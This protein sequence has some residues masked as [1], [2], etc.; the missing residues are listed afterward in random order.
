MAS[1][2]I[3]VIGGSYFL[4]DRK[5]AVQRSVN[6]Y[7]MRVEGFGED[8]QM[9]LESAPG[10][11]LVATLAGDVR[12]MR[13]AD[14]RLFVVAGTTLYE[15]VGGIAINRGAVPAGDRVS[16]TNG[17]GQLA[18][19]TSSDLLVFSLNTNTLSTVA[20]EGWRG[21]THVEYLDGYFVF[22]A[23]GTDQFYISAIDDADELDALEFSSADTQ[24]DN[25]IAHVVRKREAYFFGTR[26]CEVW[27]NSGDPDFPFAR[28][29]GTP[30]D[31]GAVGPWSVA[32]A[33]DTLVWVGQTERGGPYVYRMDGYQPVRISDQ[34]VE[35]L[36]EAADYANATCWAYQEAGGE[37]V[38]I[39][40]P[41]MSTTLVWDASTGIW[42]ERAELVDG[43]WQRLRVDHH[44][45]FNGAHYVGGGT[46]L[47]RM[48]R[49]Y[50]SL[51]GDARVMER[52]FPHFL[53]P[54]LEPIS[55]PGLE[56]RCTTGSDTQGYITLEVSN[57]GG[58]VF[59]PPLRRSLGAQGQRQ[60]RVRWLGLGTCPAGGS[61]VFRLRCTDAVHLTIQG[62]VL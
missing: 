11:E 59:G 24:P 29:Q 54:S 34:C 49:E 4:R 55:Y 42:H 15:F 53:Q 9:V 50:A 43:A 18:I 7:P 48:S 12:G 2:D 30:I 26:S 6:C 45:Y 23:P 41:G 16:M 22:V 31:V 1:R 35:Q 28:Y 32:K 57:D 44:A 8:T 37:F 56:I 21:S 60:Q 52:T 13:N 20:S 58:S 39:N 40:A 5:T 33:A 3:R 36:L 46:K 25:I 27:I 17:T 62:A 19:V 51:D 47:Y 10:L 61:R 14:G 38:C